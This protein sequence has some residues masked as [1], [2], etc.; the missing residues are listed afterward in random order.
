MLMESTSR[1]LRP[2][3]SDRVKELNDIAQYPPGHSRLDGYA[4]RDKLA[5]MLYIAHWKEGDLMWRDDF[6]RLVTKM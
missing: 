5:K 4:E 2:R 6:V 3:V 1:E